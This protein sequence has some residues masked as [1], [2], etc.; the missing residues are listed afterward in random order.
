[1]NELDAYLVSDAAA[2]Q[3]EIAAGKLLSAGAAIGSFHVIAFLGRGASSEVYRVR[4]DALKA[5]FALKIFALGEDRIRERERFLAEARLL[6]Q[7]NSPHVVRV[8]SL[9]DDGAHPFFTMDLLRPMPDAPSHSQAKHIIAGLLDALEELHSKGV[10]H[11]DI[12]PSNILLD[13]R[14]RPVVTDLGIAHVSDEAPE[15]LSVAVPRNMTIADGKAAAIGTPGYGAPEQFACGDISPATDIHAM[16]MTMLSLFG[17]RPPFLWNGL[18]RRMT[19]SAPSMRYLSVAE[20]RRAFRA[21]QF[22]RAFIIG[23]NALAVTALVIIAAS[24]MLREPTWQELDS[25]MWTRHAV[26]DEEGVIT[27]HIAMVTLRDGGHY[28][29][30]EEFHRGNVYEDARHIK[31]GPRDRNGVWHMLSNDGRR[32]GLI[33]RSTLIVRGRGVLKCRDIVGA[34]VTIGPGVTLITSG[35]C[36]PDKTI[37][38]TEVPPPDATA[39]APAYF[40]YAA[41]VVETGG[42]LIFTD[43]ADYPKG[44]VRHL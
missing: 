36:R 31:W 6:A 19:S 26:R 42:K 22:V 10:I 32:Q 15:S 14:G 33:L 40:G 12:K 17:G 38:K 5:D 1:M 8:H 4:D 24:A 16:G 34:N 2:R 39:D 11:R 18:I 41:Y 7:F 30:E 25:S 37:R 29:L 27:N 20:V 13:E 23:V 35:K 28:I 43:T 44:L 3:T 9:S 21:I